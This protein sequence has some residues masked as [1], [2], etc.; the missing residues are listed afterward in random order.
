MSEIPAGMAE[1]LARKYAILQQN[2][3]A[4][5]RNSATTALV[6]GTEAN[7]NVTRSKLLPLESAA[8]VAKIGA[9]TGLLGQQA[10][11]FGP[12]T[13]ARIENVRAGTRKIGVES[14]IATREGLTENSILPASLQSV[15]GMR[16][17]QG[18]RLGNLGS[19]F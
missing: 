17:Y 7:L 6:G 5:T 10:K 19:R 11:Y 18:F 1:Y 9:E 13:V 15:L 2:A 8:S 12:E 16:G 4:Q 14:D 3:D